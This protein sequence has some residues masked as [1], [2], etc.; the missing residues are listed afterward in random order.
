MKRLVIISDLHS[1][2]K[3]GLTHPDF[4]PGG[5]VDGSPAHKLSLLRRECWKWYEGEM[6]KLQPIDILV[7]NGDAIDGRGEKSGGTELLTVDRDEQGEIAQAAIKICKAGTIR[8]AF[9]T[10]YHCG[11]REDHEGNIAKAVGADIADFLAL[12]VNGLVFDIRHHVGGS[13]SPL[14]RFTA[15]GKEK[16]WNILWADRAERPKADVVIRSHTHYFVSTCDSEGIAI[17][18]PAL[19]AVGGK[20]GGRR[21]SGTVDFGFLSFDIEDKDV[22]TWQPHLLRPKRARVVAE[23][24]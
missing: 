8:M 9:G 14:G 4:E 11:D 3:T 13:Q 12:D 15:I 20:Y 2:H 1:G 16:V 7:V 23:R 24:V 5:F 10:P 19:Q 22:W 21:M 6:A 18:T 17:I